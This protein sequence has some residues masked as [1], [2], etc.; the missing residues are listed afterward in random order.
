MSV[1]SFLIRMEKEHHKLTAKK[2]ETIFG[3]E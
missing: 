3:I 2:N 1:D